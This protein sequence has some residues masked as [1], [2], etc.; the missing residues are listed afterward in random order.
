MSSASAVISSS[1]GD[2]AIVAVSTNVVRLTPM[3]SGSRKD[4]ALAPPIV[5]AWP[6]GGE[7]RIAAM[8]V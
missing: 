8:P 3:I 5:I 2:S 7:M 6:D 4:S 1:F